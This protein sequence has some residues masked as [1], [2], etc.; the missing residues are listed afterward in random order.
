[1]VSSVGPLVSI[2]RS[3]LASDIQDSHT[4]ILILV[5]DSVAAMHTA[6]GILKARF[7]EVYV[8]EPGVLA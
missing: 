2:S 1:M 6:P 4:G 8:R 3:S 5:F 7:Y